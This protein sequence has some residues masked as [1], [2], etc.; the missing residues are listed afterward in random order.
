MNSNSLPTVSVVSLSSVTGGASEPQVLDAEM[1]AAIWK[2]LGNA[3]PSA[4]P[5][6][7]SFSAGTVICNNKSGTAKCTE[8]K[9]K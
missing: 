1:S 5:R 3:R 2:H 4:T 7:L 6:S 8:I 9:A